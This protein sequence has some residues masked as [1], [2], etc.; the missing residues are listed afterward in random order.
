VKRGQRGPRRVGKVG[1][2]TLL[3]PGRERASAA[4]AVALAAIYRNDRDRPYG[5]Q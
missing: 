2:A 5:N 4:L 1:D 3:D